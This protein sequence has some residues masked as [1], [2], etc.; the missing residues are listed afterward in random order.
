MLRVFAGRYTNC[1]GISRR[2]FLGLGASFLGLGLADVLRLR[3]AAAEARQSGGK[4]NKSLIV[5]WTHGGM[6]QQ[7]TYDLKPDA[8]AEFRGPYRPIATAVPGIEITQRFPR[9]ARV[10][11]HLS[12]VRSVHHQNAIHAPSAHWMQTGYFGPTLARN[13]PQKPSFG[14]VIARSRGSR[15]PEMP[16]YVA[17]PKAEAFGYQG[18]VYLKP[19]YN[20]FEV[21]ADPNSP[22]FRVP[23][24]ALP[25]ELTLE[26]VRNRTQL[27]REFD[28]LRR[29]VD[30]SGTLEGL[31]SFKAQALEMVTGDRVRNAFDLS[32]EKPRLRD[33][34]GRHL[35]GQ[36]ALLARR[37]VEAGTTCVTINTGYW[38]HH[39]DIEKGL[40]EQLPPLDAAIATLVEDLEDRGMLKDAILYCAGEFG[41]TPLING[42]A[43]RD[44]WSN[45]FS[46]LI[47]GGGL[48]GGQVVGASE[49]RGGKVRERPISP[50]DLLATLYEALG[51]PLN[52]H[53]EDASGRPVS[54]VGTGKPI[55]E[56]L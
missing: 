17:I 50:N 14:S 47:G 33:R 11:N 35:Y 22:D 51:I 55:H 29:D 27:L 49:P 31:N 38:D 21:G 7:D 39:N 19:A 34:Y 10:M 3:A 32:Q 37:L 40:E 30:S 44:H 23:N 43:G 12:L 28:T 4:S 8:P 18:A 42:H 45:C 6:S 26:S 52:T 25:R 46:V 13:A 36:G 16:P 54:I 1:D 5:F 9:Q 53:Y 48:K 2:N 41:R 15:Q 24:L 56:L 20:P